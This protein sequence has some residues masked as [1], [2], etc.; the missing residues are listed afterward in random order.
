MPC[1]NGMPHIPDA[2]ESVKSVLPVG[3]YEIIVADGGSDDGTLDYLRNA[4]VVLVKG[5]DSSLYDGLNKAI[6]RVRGQYVFWLNSDDVL[7]GGIADLWNQARAQSADLATGE[8]E[9]AADGA[10][11]WRSD[12][13]AQPMSDASVLFSV[14]TVNSRLIRAGLLRRAGPFRTDI[15]LAADRHMLLKLLRLAEKR[16]F[17]NSIVYRY[18]S[19]HGSRTIGGTWKSYRDVHEANLEL[20]RALRDDMPNAEGKKLLDAFASFSIM[21]RV[22]TGFF[23]GKPSKALKEGLHAFRDYPSPKNWYSALSLYSRH[24]RHGSGW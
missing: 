23:G 9:I 8:A 22:R 19:H 10:T 7:V 15:G 1:L 3:R 2:I 16:T 21:A 24:R 12:H 11:I 6:A 20:I 14:P 17:L 13:H 4:G 18:N 5:P